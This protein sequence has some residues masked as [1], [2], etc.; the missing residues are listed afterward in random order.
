M[1]P[2]V[3]RRVGE[4][5]VVSSSPVRG[6]PGLSLRVTAELLRE[7]ERKRIPGGFQHFVLEQVG[8]QFS[9]LSCRMALGRSEC[10]K[11]VKG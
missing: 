5:Q 2:T 11:G 8:E 1:R 7:R 4:V 6:M 10:G 3:Q 9:Y